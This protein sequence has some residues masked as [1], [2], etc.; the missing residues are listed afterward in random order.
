MEKKD[1][2]IETLSM[3]G[4]GI[5]A[6]FFLWWW[7]GEDIARFFLTIKLWEL[8]LLHLVLPVGF[9]ETW[10]ERLEVRNMEEW[11][12]LEMLVLGIV[13]NIPF[14]GYP[15]YRVIAR[16]RHVSASNPGAK[17]KRVMTMKTLMA[18]EVKL[19][20]CIA[21]MMNQ[22]PLRESLTEGPWAMALKPLD[23]ARKF[24]LL[25]DER[26]LNSLDRKKLEKL[27]ISQLGRPYVGWKKMRKHE[28]ALAAISAA[29]AAGATKEA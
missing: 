23:Y 22:N 4:S 6:I 15:V 11:G 3:V 21:P 10:I 26:D 20:P 9:L 2:I 7:I 19:W 1:K 12:L 5:A 14:L 18:S 29:F 24:R 27:L 17:F 25:T 8:K 28:R 16:A 13:V